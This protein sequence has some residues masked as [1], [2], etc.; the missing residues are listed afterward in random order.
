MAAPVAPTEIVNLALDIVKAQTIENIEAPGSDD[1]A[2][3]MNRWWD[4]S[5]RKALE[6]FPWEFAA[7]RALAPLNATAPAFGYSDAYILPN[8]YVSL[9]WLIDENVPKSQY[10]YT[11]EAGQLLI[12]NSGGASIKIGYTKDSTE[13]ARWSASFKIYAAH[14]LAYYTVF[15][16]T[17]NITVTNKVQE[18]LKPARLEA[19]AVNGLNDPPKAFRQSAM[20]K[21]RREVSRGGSSELT[22]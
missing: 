13:V 8:D 10:D 9:N 11:I 7:T 4:V 17:G 12:N 16:I 20:L 3:V 19:Q 14:Q 6:G 18:L 2:V 15:K 5:R 21:A 22:V 1:V